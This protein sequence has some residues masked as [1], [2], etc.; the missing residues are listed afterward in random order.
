M[1]VISPAVIMTYCGAC[2]R[3][4][5]GKLD[6]PWPSI[7]CCSNPETRNAIEL[8]TIPDTIREIGWSENRRASKNG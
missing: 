4:D 1:L 8:S 2:H 6:A 7:A 5:K 3:I